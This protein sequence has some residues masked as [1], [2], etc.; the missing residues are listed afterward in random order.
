MKN[1]LFFLLLISAVVLSIGSCKKS[2]F[3]ATTN[4]GT[5]NDATAYNS[6]ADFDAGVA[7]AYVNLQSAFETTIRLPGFISNDVS[8]GEGNAVSFDRLFDNTYFLSDENWR[9]LYKIVNNAN[10][11]IGKLEGVEPGILTD[12][13]KNRDMGQ[14]KFLRGFAFLHLTQGFGDI[15][16]P[17]QGYTTTQNSMSCTPQ[18]DVLKQ[19]I[20][21][22]TDAADKLP[23]VQEWAGAD[24][25]RVGKGSAL[26]YLALANMYSQDWPT[27][28]AASE[29][30][31][32]LTKPK[33]ELKADVRDEFSAK[34]R[35]LTSSVFEVQ[36]SPKSADKWVGWG[37]QAPHNGHTMPTQTAPPGIGDAWVNFGGWG[38]YIISPAALSSYEPGDDRRKKLIIKYPEAY[39]GEL[40]TDSFKAKD[41]PKDVDFLA[42]RTEFGYS[43]KYWYGV[44]RL[45][46]GEN[47]IMMRFAEV[48]L[49]YAEIQFN[50]GQQAD[51]YA[52][53]NKI[54]I[55]AKLAPKAVSSDKEVFM[56]DLMNE[57]RHE[58]MLEPG[59]WYHLTRTGRAAKFLK[60]NYNITM[61]PKWEHLPIP[62]RERDV[63]P[64]LC[65]N[66][67]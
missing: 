52:Q 2:F 9:E 48:L 35:N 17:L 39:K 60:D 59:F 16:M 42:K 3:D 50:R 26:G 66:G 5:I 13:E 14:V 47:I 36:F 18:A 37:G 46:A 40:M 28:G 31:L 4:D 8:N 67:Y 7:G 45:P 20:A 25:G 64:N 29:R 62:S 63:N 44:S 1:K 43:T 41:W 10:I 55:R 57:R 24:L 15:P 51:A 11:V 58:L 33:Y 12:V 21:D 22:L 56:T 53:L 65:T 23:E 54:R 6:K 30:L 61:L 49:N 27:A 19:V 38:N 32:S 34:N